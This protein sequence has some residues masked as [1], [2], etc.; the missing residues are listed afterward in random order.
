[1]SAVLAASPRGS[2]RWSR[3][4]NWGPAVA[5][6]AACLVAVN[7]GRVILD[8]GFYVYLAGL[9]ARG[10]V[11]YRDFL[12]TQ[13]PLVLYAF[14][15]AVPF[16]SA[17]VI[18]ARAI[19][20]GCGVTAVVL[21][22]RAAQRVGGGGAVGWAAA[23]LAL[24]ASFCYD[25]CTAR[26]LGLA[27]LL[28]AAALHAL[29]GTPGDRR[30]WARAAAWLSLATC[31]R[32]SLAPFAALVAV[33]G[34]LAM[35]RQP[36]ERRR[37]LLGVALPAGAVLGLFA[38]LGGEQMWFGTVAFHQQVHGP[39]PGRQML[40]IFVSE[41]L[42][43]E[44]LALAAG[45]VGAVALVRRALSGGRATCPAD[46][47]AA[48][49]YVSW[50]VITILHATRPAPYAAHQTATLPLLA[51]ST[52][53]ALGCGAQRPASSRWALVACALALATVPLQHWPLRFQERGSLRGVARA[54]RAVREVA[55]GR[56]ILTFDPL[57]AVASGSPNMAGYELGMFSYAPQ[58][59]SAERYHLKDAPAL[60]RDLALDQPAVVALQHRDVARLLATQGAVPIVP[61]LQRDYRLIQEISGYGQFE[62]TLVLLVPAAAAD[63]K[64]R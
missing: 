21:V 11:P 32:L 51:F 39:D 18:A 47:L 23:S 20:A 57:L 63:G 10:H 9:A 50:V 13:T 37:V 48:L 3:A 33:A 24:N 59:P 61:M 44:G 15:P 31:V 2:S 7:Y 36:G 53:L 54:G 17:G 6:A 52:A 28:V 49:G 26:P 46:P 34:L 19:S 27:A 22:L 29:A 58:V 42:R 64:A 8:E 4:W 25:V 35:H 43:N 41:V 5:F 55:A 12:F 40:R 45:V 38:A 1:M 60:A 30:G 16:G 62:Q 14:A 56:P